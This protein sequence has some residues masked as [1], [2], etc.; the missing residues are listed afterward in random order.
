[1]K[2]TDTTLQFAVQR[3]GW[4]WISVLRHALFDKMHIQKPT[5]VPVF[6][7]N[8]PKRRGPRTDTHTYV[9]FKSNFVSHNF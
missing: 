3:E 5:Q 7:E 9:K 8:S 6:Q 2:K 4:S 1:M